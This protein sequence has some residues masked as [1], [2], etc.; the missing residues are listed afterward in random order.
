MTNFKNQLIGS[1]KNSSLTEKVIFGFLVILL[2]GA[3][4]SSLLKVNA[5]YLVEIPK[6]GGEL[7]EGL[8]GTPRFVNPVIAISDTDRDISSLI[9]SGLLRINSE[10][11]LVEDLAESFEVSEDGL[12]YFVKI[13]DDAFF[14]DG[15]PVTVDDVILTIKQTQDPTVKSPKRP[16]WDGVIIEK[17]DDKK[18]NF[19]LSQPYSPFIHNLTLGILPSHIWEKISS[20]EFAFSKFNLEPIGSGPYVIKRVARDGDGIAERY[21]L[22]S[23][24]NYVLGEPFVKKI[25]FSFYKNEDELIHALNTNS[26][27]SAHGISPNKTQD[28]KTGNK[29]ITNVP[30]SRIFAIFLNPSKNE[31]FTSKEVRL[32]LDRAL[33]KEE[34]IDNFFAGY[35]TPID[36]PLPETGDRQEASDEE[37]L[38]SP[39]ELLE[40]DGWSLDED[41][42]YGKETEDSVS[43]LSFSI[44]T[45]N[46]D[47]L[48]QVAESVKDSWNNLGAE[49]TLKIFEPND[50][51]LNVIRPRE[52]ESILFGQV[53]KKDLDLYGFWHSS[54]RSDPGLNISG[55]ANIDSDKALEDARTLSNKEARTEAL[56]KFE[57]EVINDVPAIFLYS[58][59][60][61]YVTPKS[62]NN[63]IPRNI[64]I[65]SD[66]FADI[67]KWF[68]ET[69]LVW[70]VFAD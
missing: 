43:T 48:V 25:E 49:V 18:I 11:Q 14:H 30:L 19:V 47:E 64:V 56:Q 2:V 50:L 42:I 33:G 16:N 4:L 32:A 35:A 23:Y 27:T 3:G 46:V 21:I 57:K 1:I 12:V 55:Y 9:Y 65:S 66:R 60:F 67:H 51:T 34:I 44:S 17:V 69:D 52:F 31:I 68:V 24:K 7:K 37:A 26:I 62:L 29:T 20:D 28:I 15:N 59:D 10:G 13:R 61:I 53:I 70:K 45:A 54:Q 6:K 8:I 41:G 38:K 63:E 40:S 22:E 39:Q 5:N 58:P 36:G